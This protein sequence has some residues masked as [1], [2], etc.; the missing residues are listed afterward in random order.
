MPTNDEIREAREALGLNQSEA[1]ALLPVARETWNR[2]EAG[3]Q[4]M[5]EAEWRY[6]KHVAGLERIPFKTRKPAGKD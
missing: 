1:A 3:T 6:W 5:T 2:Y 4:T